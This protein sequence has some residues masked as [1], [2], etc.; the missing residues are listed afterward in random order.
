MFLVY[1]SSRL[2]S[3]TGGELEGGQTS[4]KKRVSHLQPEKS[5]SETGALELEPT[6]TKARL[7]EDVRLLTEE[8]KKQ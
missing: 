8:W 2:E 7:E 5:T 6:A 3:A 1:V 4:L